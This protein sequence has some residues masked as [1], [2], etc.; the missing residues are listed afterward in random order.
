MI[1]QLREKW[2][3][4]P[5]MR[6]MRKMPE[7]FRISES[8]ALNYFIRGLKDENSII[9]VDEKDQELN[10]F[11]FASIEELEGNDVCFIHTCIINPKR[12]E[13]GFEF[14]GRLRKWC[15]EK[16]IKNIFMMSNTHI[17]GYSQK[18]KFET[19]AT[20]MKLKVE[21]RQS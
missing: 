18:Y 1:Y 17:K 6:M 15:G 3:V 9:I 19:Y 13:T 16:N 7:L 11:L 4:A 14:I 10:G 12:K 5:I 20:I 21:E 2:A 8:K